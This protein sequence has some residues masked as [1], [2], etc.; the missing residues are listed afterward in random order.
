MYQNEKFTIKSIMKDLQEITSSNRTTSAAVAI[1]SILL[2][3][4]IISFA[5]YS[6]YNN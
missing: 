3:I 1:I 4:C 5:I 2:A 6:C